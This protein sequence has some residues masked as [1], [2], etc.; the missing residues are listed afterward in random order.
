MVD[1][2]NRANLVIAHAREDTV[3][4]DLALERGVVLETAGG[5]FA[6]LR[7]RGAVFHRIESIFLGHALEFEKKYHFELEY[8][9]LPLWQSPRLAPL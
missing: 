3:D 2:L 6:I 9:V 7:R 4:G 5:Q 1:E 8:R